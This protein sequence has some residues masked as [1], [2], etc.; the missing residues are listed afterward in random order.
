MRKQIFGDDKLETVNDVER[1][2]TEDR[3]NIV[4]IEVLKE[5][6]PAEIEKLEETL[7]IYFSGIDLEILK[8]K[9]PDNGKYLKKI[10]RSL[11]IFQ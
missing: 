11:P 4:S 6:F 2:I 5:D 8:T 3:F 7:N 1:L 10:S 9:F